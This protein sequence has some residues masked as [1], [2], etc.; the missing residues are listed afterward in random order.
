MFMLKFGFSPSVR[1]RN[2]TRSLNWFLTV[3]SVRV[4]VLKRGWPWY[5]KFSWYFENISMPRAAMLVT[6]IYGI[7]AGYSSKFIKWRSYSYSLKRKVGFNQED[8]KNR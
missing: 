3:T 6:I 1:I 5:L 4:T 2:S 7:F 8:V